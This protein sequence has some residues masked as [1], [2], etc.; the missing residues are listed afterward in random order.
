MQGWIGDSIDALR[1]TLYVDADFASDLR[2]SKSTSGAYL[3]LVSPQPFFPII[4]AC[5]TQGCVS[6]SSTEAEIVSLEHAM[7]SEALPLITRWDTMYNL[8]TNNSSNS[9]KQAWHAQQGG[10]HSSVHNAF[11]KSSRKLLLVLCLPYS[12]RT[13]AFT[14]FSNFLLEHN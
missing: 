11:D 7:R 2:T 10:V 13:I 14:K 4:S 8:K 6:Q 1:L 5:K 9:N 12:R 3:C